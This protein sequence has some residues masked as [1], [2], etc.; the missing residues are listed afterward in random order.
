MKLFS[1]LLLSL[2]L[3]LVS[4][5]LLSSSVLAA[6]NQIT[7]VPSKGYSQIED[8]SI[9]TPIPTTGFTV[10]QQDLG[11]PAYSN[12]PSVLGQS[13]TKTSPVVTDYFSVLSRVGFFVVLI[14][15]GAILVEMIV[16]RGKT[17]K[18][19]SPLLAVATV[20]TTPSANSSESSLPTVSQN[21]SQSL[22]IVSSPANSAQSSQLNT[23]SVPIGA[24]IPSLTTPPPAPK[25]TAVST[26]LASLPPLP[27]KKLDKKTLIL[28]IIVVFLLLSI[29]LALIVVKQRQEVRKQAEGNSVSVSCVSRPS[30]NSCSDNTQ[31]FYGLNIVH[32]F[33]SVERCTYCQSHQNEIE[34]QGAALVGQLDTC[35]KTASCTPVGQCTA[36]TSDGAHCVCGFT[37]T[38][39]NCSVVQLDCLN[40]AYPGGGIANGTIAWNCTGPCGGAEVTPTPTV[41]EAPTPTVTSPI[42]PTPTA[43]GVITPTPTVTSAITPTVTG[44]PTATP[45]TGPTATPTPI[46]GCADKQ[47]NTNADCPSD[48]PYCFDRPSDSIS[49]K[50]CVKN[51]SWYN[52]C[53]PNPSCG[54]QRCTQDSE[55]PSDFPYCFNRPS[56]STNDQV[57]VI[58]KSWNDG[59]NPP[60]TAPTPTIA[61][62]SI[63]NASFEL[64]AILSIIGG[65]ALLL[66]GLVL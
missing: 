9:V 29:P 10:L 19:K 54:E 35:G 43:T 36:N 5:T 7:P 14:I 31:Q 49:V 47:C 64:P 3:F 58:N 28:G 8:F 37:Q 1:R 57:C 33:D 66:I 59:C 50:L 55:C 30:D 25:S 52:G 6:V 48:F 41:T 63:P 23:I 11:Q 65:A 16:L 21:S 20:G 12:T 2:C 46:P 39:P 24:S 13:V 51:T 17:K 26:P 53:S 34:C 62:P 27:K 32:T 56:D 38:I 4:L 42:T 45:T 18:N 61:V 15:L 60:G 44:A 40:G 22:P